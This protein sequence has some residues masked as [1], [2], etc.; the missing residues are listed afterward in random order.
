MLIAMLSNATTSYNV[1]SISLVLKIMGSPNVYGDV[2]DTVE[3]TCSSA[4]L[5][6]MTFGQLLFGSLGDVIGIDRA[7]A[8]T[9]STQVVGCIGSAAAFQ[10]S[11]SVSSV[12][13]FLAAFR[14][15]LGIGCGGVYP[16]AANMASKTQKKKDRGQSVAL[17]FSMQ[18]I[19]YIF[20]PILALLFIRLFGEDSPVV[21]R[22]LLGFGAI[23]GLW[24]LYLRAIQAKKMA[25]DLGGGGG[26]G[27]GGGVAPRKYGILANIR[28]EPK[29]GR[30]LLGTA[31]CWMLFDV[32]FYGNVLF[33][34]IVL[35]AAFGDSETITDTA[36]DDLILNAIGLPG[37][38]VSVYFMGR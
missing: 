12:F 22:L 23:P 32:L 2:G 8:L 15:V 29:L 13:Y 9:I 28:K 36:I 14:F 33:K 27:G 35:E 30:K 34:P 11:A 17:V 19:G 25:K 6:G 1:V 7:M 18:G 21:W 3:S 10:T 26:G 37:Y 20:A 38:F 24:L 5:A 16:L 4:L 31:I